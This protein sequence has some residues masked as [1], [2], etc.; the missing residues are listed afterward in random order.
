MIVV[1]VFLLM[2]GGSDS[3]FVGTWEYTTEEFGGM[4]M[5]YKFNGDGSLEITSSFGNF[6]FGSW[7]VKGNQL[8]FEADEN[9]PYGTEGL[10]GE[11]CSNYSFS[12]DGRQLTLTYNGSSIILTKK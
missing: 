12:S 3:R 11:Q 4:S 10:I 8:C 6:K 9:L 5:G 2:G 7:S 1:V